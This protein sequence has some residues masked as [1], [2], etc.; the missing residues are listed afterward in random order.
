MPPAAIRK[1]DHKLQLTEFTVLSRKAASLLWLA[2]LPNLFGERLGGLMKMI[3]SLSFRKLH[4]R[5]WYPNLWLPSPPALEVVQLYRRPGP[6]LA[7]IADRL[8]R[9]A[10]RRSWPTFARTPKKLL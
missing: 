4:S 8:Q 5:F 6:V 10:A 1:L 7:I 3:R 2:S 9:I